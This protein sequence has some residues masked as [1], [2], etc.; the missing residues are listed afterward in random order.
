MRV[1]WQLVVVVAI[2]VAGGGIVGA[3]QGIAWLA[4]ALGLLTAALAVL[5]YRW[6]VSRTERRSPVELGGAGAG[7]AVGWGILAG[8][9]LFGVVIA[10]IA[11]FGGYTI[12]GFG[13]VA[14]LMGLVGVMAVAATTEELVFRG[15]L[16]RIVEERAG[17][18]VGLV[19]T[20][21]V[22][23]LIHL[24]NPNASLWGALAI[25]VEAG[26]L[27][28]A[29]YV[30]T[31]RLWLPIGLHFGWNIAAGGIFSTEVSGSG[32]AQGLLDA[33]TS[34][35]ALLTGGAFGPEGSIFSLLVCVPAAAALLWLAHRRGHM[36]P[37]RR[38]ARTGTEVGTGTGTARLAR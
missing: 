19:L 30:A 33:A 3:T 23:G 26:G 18:W 34:G 25:G 2:A 10:C 17:T 12:H 13:S 22:F 1:V 35:P 24:L 6:V 29:A 11:L 37:F 14:G 31:R 7:A 9:G 36:V 4:L 5:A 38:S 28:T 15:V 27:L 21:L 16:F 8:V 20:G 32:T